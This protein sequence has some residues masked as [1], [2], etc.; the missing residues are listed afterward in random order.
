MW[1]IVQKAIFID[2]D[3]YEDLCVNSRLVF[4]KKKR[5]IISESVPACGAGRC[6][7]TTMAIVRPRPGSVMNNNVGILK[8]DEMLTARTNCRQ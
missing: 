7:L 5:N 4:P 2:K 8:A 3:R 6:Y 1:S